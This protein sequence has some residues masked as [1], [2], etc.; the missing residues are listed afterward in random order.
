MNQTDEDQR[1][2]A[3]TAEQKFLHSMEQ[4]FYY[5][6]RVAEAILLEAQESLSGVS[7]GVHPGQMCVVLARQGAPNGQPM[8]ETE[9]VRILWTVDQGREDRQIMRQHGVQALRQARIVRLL[10]EAVD[11]GAAASQEDLAWVLQSSLRTIKRDCAQLQ[12]AGYYLPTRGSLEKVGRG[13]THKAHI[14]RHWLQGETYDQIA[15]RMRHS[16]KSIQR[17]LKTFVQVVLLQ[18][19]GLSD[20]QIA[21]LLQMG[22]ALVKEYLAV[23][24]ENDSEESRKRLEE[25]LQRLSQGKSGE[26]G[27]R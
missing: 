23:Y 15:L 26:K 11:Q 18:R 27:A 25:Q 1:A 10:D 9:L 4:D 3:K 2:Q 16:A 19:Q 20:S 5:P 8:S 12:A 21:R 7:G 14:I 6:P 24:A 22:P 13:Q 17:Y